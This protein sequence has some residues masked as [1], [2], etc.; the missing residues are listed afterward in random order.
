[1]LTLKYMR[2]WSI[3]FLLGSILLASCQKNTMSKIP[4]IALTYAGPDSIRANYDTAFIMFNFTD[5]D[6]DLGNDTAKS[7]VFVKDKRYD[8]TGA[9]FTKYNFPDIDPNIE[10]PKKGITG[11]GVILLL[12]PP[13]VPRSDSFHMVKGDTTSY[14]MYITD[15]AGN[16]SNHITTRQIIVRP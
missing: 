15:R 4:H 9:T 14:E 16:E 10:D 8:T 7:C 2:S 1:M 11:N 6:A 13:L 5:G 3:V 12:S